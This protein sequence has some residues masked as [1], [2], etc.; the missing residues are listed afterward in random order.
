MYGCKNNAKY[1]L[2]TALLFLSFVRIIDHRNRRVL[3]F[4][5]REI[6]GKY[7]QML[8]VIIVTVLLIIVSDYQFAQLIISRESQH[9]MYNHHGNDYLREYILRNHIYLKN[10]NQCDKD[11]GRIVSLHN[12]YFK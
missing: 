4:E 7:Q 8:S 10:R 9:N 11:G 3:S 2:H 1:C 12:F 6:Y 5:K